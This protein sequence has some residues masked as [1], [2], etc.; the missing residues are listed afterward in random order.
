[1]KKWFTLIEIMIVLAII[2]VITAMTMWFW[3]NRIQQ[4]RYQSAKELFVDT[5]E[6]LR[7]SAL[8]S[9]FH[10]KKKFALFTIQLSQNNTS[11]SYSYYFDETHFDT[12]QEKIDN[13]I[14]IENISMHTGWTN[15][16]IVEN[17]DNISKLAI[18]NIKPYQLSCNFSFDNGEPEE[19]ILSFELHI[20]NS[21]KKYCFTI[22]SESCRI[23]EVKCPKAI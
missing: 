18:L 2:G 4:L 15:K 16:N 19:W 9:S 6:Q 13:D 12:Y 14:S 1:M 23:I 5:F 7:S 21:N 11:L 3:W 22:P 17:N 10:N 8:T 20:K